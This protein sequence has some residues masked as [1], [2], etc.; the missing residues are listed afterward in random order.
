MTTIPEGSI[1]ITPT[2]VY[3]KV[4]LLT[5]QV[6]KLLAQDEAEVNERTEMRREI[7]A[8]GERVRSLENKVWLASGFCAAIGSGLGATFATI[9]G[10]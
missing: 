6:T 2:Q 5:E 10:H 4:N 3:D 1:V 9:L 8:L 7:K